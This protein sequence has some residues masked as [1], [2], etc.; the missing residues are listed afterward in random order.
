LVL[1]S[2]DKNVI[3]EALKKHQKGPYKPLDL[4][5]KWITWRT[6]SREQGV[7]RINEFVSTWKGLLAEA[8]TQEEDNQE[9]LMA[10]E[11]E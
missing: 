2:L 9:A 3:P 10:D 4:K 11:D 1:D 7:D 5:A 8:K 6:A